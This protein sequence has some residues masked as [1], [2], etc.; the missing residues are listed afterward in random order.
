MGKTSRPIN[1]KDDGRLTTHNRIYQ[2]IYFYLLSY[3]SNSNLLVLLILRCRRCSL[4]QRC[5]SPRA[6][7][8]ARAAHSRRTLWQGPSRTCGVS[9]LKRPCWRVL[10]IALPTRVLRRRVLRIALIARGTRWRV[11]LRTGSPLGCTNLMIKHVSLV[12][13]LEIVHVSCSSWLL[14]D[15]ATCTSPSCLS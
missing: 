1:I 2:Y 5:W 11:R 15:V 9:G 10:H 8:P 12:L 4:L 7:R 6:V 3:F 14:G 13:I